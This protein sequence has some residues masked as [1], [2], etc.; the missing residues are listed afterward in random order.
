MATTF[1]WAQPAGCAITAT[2]SLNS[3]APAGNVSYYQDS[4]EDTPILTQSAHVAD[5][6]RASVRPDCASGDAEEHMRD[7]ARNGPKCHQRL[8]ALTPST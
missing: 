6:G 7:R 1:A 5:I 8:V 4:D 2:R 3:T